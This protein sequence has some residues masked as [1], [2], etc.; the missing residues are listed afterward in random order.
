MEQSSIL[1]D[2]ITEREIEDRHAKT[3]NDPDEPE[4]Y[5]DNVQLNVGQIVIWRT[6]N[7]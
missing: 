6:M 5:G 7:H 4:L 2:S 1:D 3:V